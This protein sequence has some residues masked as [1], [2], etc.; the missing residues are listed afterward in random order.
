MPNRKNER[1]GGDGVIRH[2]HAV[3]EN[4]CRMR[5][6]RETRKGIFLL[7]LMHQTPHASIGGAFCVL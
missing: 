6:N 3:L 5:P 7:I 2:R 1:H 4:T